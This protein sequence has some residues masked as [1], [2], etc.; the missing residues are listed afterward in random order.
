MLAADY[1]TFYNN[2]DDYCDKVAEARETVIITRKNEKNVVIISLDDYNRMAKAERNK[3][4]LRRVDRSLAQ[5]SAG[6]CVPHELIEV[7]DE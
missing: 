3:S 7:E 2:L 6:K 4:Y 1:L 5:Y